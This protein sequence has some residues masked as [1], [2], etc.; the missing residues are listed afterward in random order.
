L[1]D[2]TIQEYREGISHVKAHLEPN[3]QILD[4]TASQQVPSQ[5]RFGKDLTVRTCVKNCEDRL[6][7]NDRGRIFVLERVNGVLELF[8]ILSWIA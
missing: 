4:V 1:G 8:T 6:P 3:E 2:L 7:G 5:R